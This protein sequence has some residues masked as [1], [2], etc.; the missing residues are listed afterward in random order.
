MSRWLDQVVQDLRFGVRTLVGAPGFA[1]L[2]IVSLALGIMATTAMYSVVRAVV[3]DPFPYKDVDNL[4]SIRV[5]DPSGRGGRT[6]YTTDQYLEFARRATIFDGV[7]AST[8]S[9]VIWTG[10]GNPQRLRGNHIT[11]TTF[12]VMGVPP[13]LGRAVRPADGVPGAPPVVVLG[14]KFWQRQ[15]GGEASAVGR[16]MLLNGVNR[17]VV[18]VM[19]KRFMWRGADVYVPVV[20]EQGKVVEG[21]RNVHVLGRLKAGVTEAQAEADLRPIVA[22]L[23]QREPAQFPEGRWRVGLLSF[24][25]TF[26]SNLGETLWILFAAVGLLL[27]IACVNVS[28]LLLSRAATRQREMALRAAIGA[29]RARLVRQLLT[30]SLLIALGGALLGIPLAYGG[31][32]AIIALVPP[33]TIPDESEIVINGAVLA[34][35]VGISMATAVIF[36]LAPAWQGSSI[37]LTESLK[38]GARSVTGGRRQAIMSNGLV[39]AEV[40]LSVMLLVGAALMM[41]TLVAMQNVDLGVRPERLMTMRVPLVETRYPDA[42]R[43]VAFFQSL[44]TRLENAPGVRGAA[45]SSGVHPFGGW[46]VPIEVPGSGSQDSR[47]AVF[48]QVSA[49]YTRTMGIP[50]LAGRGLE[51]GDVDRRQ[52]TAL[53]NQALVTRYF[54]D[55]NALG[56]TVRVPRLRQ[57]PASLENDTFEIVGVVGNTVSRGLSE[58]TRPELYVPFSL[59]GLAQSVAVRTDGEPERATALVRAEVAALD[60]DQP[61]SDIR[62]L[63]STLDDYMFAGPRFGLTLFAVF[64]TLGLTLA[65]VGVYGVIAHAVSRR[66]QEIGVRM[67]LGATTDRIVSMVLAGGAK[68]VAA[69]IVIGLAGSALAARAMRELIWNVSPWD[70]VSFVAVAAVLMVVGLQATLWPALRATRVNPVAALRKQ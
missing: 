27:L 53:V 30:E 39:I 32:N 69:G 46:L 13:L 23:A 3:L 9:D 54:G 52:M 40:A 26:E 38:D 62:S 10:A 2:A 12:D 70:P 21:V 42:T 6:Y 25:E 45:V 56:R 22:D 43:R 49:G 31:L 24:K 36:G 8:I 51:I 66:T 44:L 16:Q 11:T 35:T 19:P 4:M 14:F 33:D 34:F 20:F 68:L 57:P 67:A 28:N 7:I 50:L 65:V 15:F 61:L 63:E 41:R 17:T 47:P 1:A 37:D 64:A 60:R 48:H 58:L 5:A 55:G 29:G 18:G 59:V